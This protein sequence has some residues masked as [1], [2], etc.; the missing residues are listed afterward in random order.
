LLSSHEV[1]NDASCQSLRAAINAE[2]HRP[3]GNLLEFRDETSTVLDLRLQ[4]VEITP[5]APG[6]RLA[7]PRV[8]AAIMQI[9]PQESSVAL[10]LIQEHIEIW[11]MDVLRE[12]VTTPLA[13]II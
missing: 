1:E 10:L 7:L 2:L 5:P 6:W 11:T 9:R 4:A 13:E 12:S 3:T 8:S